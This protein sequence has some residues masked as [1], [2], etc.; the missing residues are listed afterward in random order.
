M[1][2]NQ[3]DHAWAAGFFEGEGLFAL[4]VY[5]RG[6]VF[7]VAVDQ[8]DPA[9]LYKLKHLYGGT[10]C[11]KQRGGVYAWQLRTKAAILSCL[12]AIRPYLIGPKTIQ[13]SLMLEGLRSPPEALPALA[14]RIKEA[15]Q[16]K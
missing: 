15:K 13:A 12:A 1:S 9:P 16:Y 10:I 8:K 14:A 7:T 4:Y 2:K 11:R 6:P 3:I 5:E